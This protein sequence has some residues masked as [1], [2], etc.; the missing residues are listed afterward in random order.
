MTGYDHA[1]IKPVTISNLTDS[2][3]QDIPTGDTEVQEGRDVGN[4]Y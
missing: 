3:D 2:T 4:F 1:I